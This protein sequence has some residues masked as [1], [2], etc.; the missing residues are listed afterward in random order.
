MAEAGEI[1][2]VLTLDRNNFTIESV[3][4]GE[5]IRALKKD[6]D[7]TVNSVKNISGHMDSFGHGLKG[8]IISASLT[9]YALQDIHDLFLVMPM[10]IL[11]S[12]GEIE[13]LQKLMEGLS[14]ETDAYK[15]KIEAAAGV[16]FVFNMAQNAP[17]EVKA[18]SDSFVKLKVAGIDPTNGSMQALVDSV[19]KFGGSS[20][21]LHRAS[22]AIQQMAGKGVVSM[23]ELRQQLG[24]AVPDAMQL[25]A[26][27]MGLSMS[28][29]AKEIKKGTVQ[30]EDAVSKMLWQMENENRGAAEAMMTTWTGMVEKLKTKWTL[31]QN[32][33]ASSGFAQ[34]AKDELSA[35]LDSFDSKQIKE[36]SDTIGKAL[37]SVVNILSWAKNMFVQYGGEIQA[38]LIGL[39]VTK[40]A[41][42]VRPF[43]AGMNSIITSFKAGMTAQ[44]VAAQEHLV[45][46][47]MAIAQEIAANEQKTVALKANYAEQAAAANALYVKQAEQYKMLEI[48]QYK[49]MSSNAGWNRVQQLKVEMEETRLLTG[50]TAILRDERYRDVKAIEAEVAAQMKRVAALEA[51]ILA[52]NGAATS[53]RLLGGA[54][55]ALGNMLATVGQ[56][57]LG[58]GK[59]MAMMGAQ[60]AAVIA[61]VEGA[62][63]V[64][65]KMGR[66]AEQSAKRI[67]DAR[68]AMAD[69]KKGI[70]NEGADIKM[71]NQLDIDKGRLE[72]LIKQ[73][74][75]TAE[76][77]AARGEEIAKLRKS[78]DEQEVAVE[79]MKVKVQQS[80]FT[81][82]MASYDLKLNR[83][84]TDS[85][86]GWEQRSNE[87]QAKIDA[88]NADVKAKILSEDKAQEQINKIKQ[89]SIDD[90][91]GRQTA[92]LKREIAE[93][94][95]AL[96]ERDA[97]LKKMSDAEYSA[98]V[99]RRDHAQQ[100]M[101]ELAAKATKN[102]INPDSNVYVGKH[103][104]KTKKD[105]ADTAIEREDFL[106][107]AIEDAK[108][109]LEVAKVDMQSLIGEMDGF[110][111]LKAKAALDI[112]GNVAEGKYDKKNKDGTTDFVGA[113]GAGKNKDGT[114]D[115][116]KR[117]ELV[118]GLSRAFAAG[119]TDVDAYINSLTTLNEADKQNIITLV[120]K[121][122]LLKKKN[123]ED[124]AAIAMDQEVAKAQEAVNQATEYYNSGGLAKQTTGMKALTEHIA[125]MRKELILA[126]GD[127]ESLD[128]KANNAKALQSIADARTFRAD[129]EKE[130]VKA[131]VDAIETVA[132]R[133]QRD[134]EEVLRQ[135]DERFAMHASALEKSIALEEDGSD[136]KK[137]LELELAKL[138]STLNQARTVEDMKYQKAS[139]SE[140]EKLLITWSDTTEQMNKLSANW[141]T[142]FVDMVIKATDTGKLE[143]KGFISS[144]LNDLKKM[145]IQGTFAALMKQAFGVTMSFGGAGGGVFGSGAG[146]AGGT[147]GS[148]GNLV[149]TGSGLYQ[150]YTGYTAGTGTGMWGAAGNWLGGQAGTA[151]GGYSTEALAAMNTYGGV[152]ASVGGQGAG[153][154]A[155]TGTST[156][157]AASSAL[158][159][160]GWIAALYMAADYFESKRGAAKHEGDSFQTLADTGVTTSNRWV[161]GGI[162][163]T[164]NFTPQISNP[165]FGANGE[166][167]QDQIASGINPSINEPG[168]LSTDQ[169]VG[170][171]LTP[172]TDGIRKMIADLGGDA[173]G[174]SFALGY[175]TDPGGTAGDQVLSG[176]ADASGNSV[177]SGGGEFG[178]GDA[179]KQ[180]Q[181]EMQR[182]M[183]AAVKSADIEKIYKSFAGAGDISKM[184]SEEITNVLNNLAL[185][186]QSFSTLTGIFKDSA[187][188]FSGTNEQTLA[189]V[190]G[191]HDIQSALT[192]DAFK[193]YA[194]SVEKTNSSV[195]ALDTASSKIRDLVKSYDG[196]LASV[197]TLSAA[198]T[199]F[200]QIELQ[201][202]QQLSEASKATSASIQQSISDMKYSV[203]DDK[204]KY[205]FIDAE[206]VGLQ[207]KMKTAF[208][209]QVISQYTDQIREDVMKAFNLLPEEARAGFVTQYERILNDTDA[210][211]Q[212]RYKAIKDKADLDRT[213]NNT[214]ISG[215]LKI[216]FDEWT[217]K[218]AQIAEQQQQAANT[219]LVAANTPIQVAVNVNVP[220]SELNFGGD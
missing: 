174:M 146:G 158:T 112:L 181:L 211:A 88:I 44:D 137:E 82:V 34:A 207:E 97:G 189:F 49:A 195:S 58:F 110:Q 197:Q 104:G 28:Q 113:E 183:L 3:R 163:F 215:A 162:G 92:A 8:L 188:V 6:L 51:E 136:R 179:Q 101:E 18:L 50:S 29:L 193:D 120:E 124:K 109:K 77:L 114:T 192:A 185:L 217:A 76:E 213:A 194:D 148:L 123:A 72:T 103:S 127:V 89:A 1:K 91:V 73:R 169:I 53:T 61:V 4:A 32:D 171:M 199:E 96:K 155:T 168:A 90:N 159:A 126:G 154:L 111:A 19:A 54:K 94:T 56:S 98:E 206:I 67:N 68:Q 205:S 65:N 187:N 170:N 180:L 102:R 13:R 118:E 182:M 201:L 42:M 22:I 117:K 164:D 128:K 43:E 106:V 93:R 132:G 144:V 25:M 176:V 100:R 45:R 85:L 218:Q 135:I 175:S 150:A 133:R 15:R 62:M 48:A 95:A 198:T 21:H 122:A 57:V 165:A 81:D 107:R 178:R 125:K 84:T 152:G 63:W 156:T 38:L 74:F 139:Q 191:L 71:Q 79:E 214:A 129:Q 14:K 30:T 35:L 26:Q 86:S 209:P 24:E 166:H 10:S 151:L 64:W 31:L 115:L 203:L 2:V 41:G 70:V 119:Q 196:S 184:T 17:F 157:G 39:F 130:F 190:A 161:D 216:V 219:Q 108:S 87:R 16:R 105:K 83:L 99:V 116:S 147:M 47:K 172:V 177:Y 5:T 149:S 66:E 23:E 78:I 60:F 208:D 142:N 200:Y 80:G 138:R 9:R 37:T 173:T 20:E 121:L 11:K 46:S 75:G 12:A 40:M 7:S 69:F 59:S 145:A 186:K 140:L 143:W 210:V 212:D 134:H 52:N 131:Q 167:W 153:T 204:G 27:G 202:A 141:A 36:F 33:I 160:V 220:K 55:Q